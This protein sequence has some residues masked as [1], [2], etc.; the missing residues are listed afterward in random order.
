MLHKKKNRKRL[1]Q[2]RKRLGEVMPLTLM[3]VVF[4]LAN[5]GERGRVRSEGSQMWSS[6]SDHHHCFLF[7]SLS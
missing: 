3:V 4:T 5:V 6:A 1:G 7:L 2:A